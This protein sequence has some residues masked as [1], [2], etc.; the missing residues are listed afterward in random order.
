M[1]KDFQASIDLIA[2]A[3]IPVTKVITRR[4]L[5]DDIAEAFEIAADKRSGA[6]KVQIH[7]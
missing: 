5:L 6:I 1:K 4:F 3:K 2:S 7:Q